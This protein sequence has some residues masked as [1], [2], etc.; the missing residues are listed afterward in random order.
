MSDA[1]QWHLIEQLA[2]FCFPVFNSLKRLAANGRVLQNDDTS[3]KI[4]DVIKLIKDGK[5]GKR[6]GMYTTGVLVDY[7]DHK[8]A[9]FINGRQHSGENVNDIL[10]LRAPEKSPI[11]QMCDALSANLPKGIQTILCNCLSHGFRKFE[12]LVDYC[13]SKCIFIIQKLSK[14]FEYD[15]MTNKMSPEE[16]LAYHQAHSKPIM[17]ELEQ[18]MRLLLTNKLVEPNSDFGRAI[19][20]MQR[21]WVKLTKF[22]TVAGAP[23]CNNIVERALKIAIRNRKA[24]MFYKTEYSANIG[25]VITSLI[26]TCDLAKENPYDYLI[27]LQVH[28]TSV[29]HRPDQWLPWNY[30]DTLARLKLNDAKPQARAPP[31][32]HPVAA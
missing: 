23:I 18:Y 10:K 32:D 17:D 3:L 11:I 7:E 31:A 30:R 28:A 26:Y 1:T 8:I 15:E 14:V 4:L 16:R 9:L 20:Y 13:D 12:E 21:H 29:M 19:K 6:T 27:A 25:G 24:S 5:A 22:L 2:G